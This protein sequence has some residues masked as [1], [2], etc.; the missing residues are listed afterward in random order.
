M[1]KL[2]LRKIRK[3][4]FIKSNI[5]CFYLFIRVVIQATCV[6]VLKIKKRALRLEIKFIKFFHV[7]LSGGT[8]L[9][10]TEIDHS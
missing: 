3:I 8:E 5:L 10:G 2:V 6:K 7:L 4:I 9:V 1:G